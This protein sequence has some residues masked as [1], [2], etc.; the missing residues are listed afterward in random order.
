MTRLAMILGMVMVLPALADAPA[1]APLPASVK[2]AKA[3]HDED[4]KQAEATFLKTEL[5]AKRTYLQAV[6]SAI[7]DSMKAGHLDEANAANEVKQQIE[8][9]IDAITLQISGWEK[10]VVKVSA[11]QDWQATIDLARGDVV[12]IMAEGTWCS[13]NA[14]PKRKTWD[15]NGSTRERSS[16]FVPNSAYS[17]LIGQFNGER[18]VV[19]RSLKVTAPAPGTLELRINDK[20]IDDNSGELT[21]TVLIKR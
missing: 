11:R 12:Q 19:G 16:D 10:K 21:V 6:K 4:V 15:A 5:A 2:H 14:D 17:G 3:K 8:Q 9:Q 13:F 7:A 1:D 18:F 20:G